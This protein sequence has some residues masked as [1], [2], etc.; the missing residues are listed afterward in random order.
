MI[1]R[2][3]VTDSSDWDSPLPEQYRSELES[4]KTKLQCLED[5]NIRRTYMKHDASLSKAVRREIHIFSDAF[6]KAIAAVAYL[7]AVSPDGEIHVG[8][9]LGKANVGP[10]H[11]N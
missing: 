3:V 5:V 9:I 10:K 2:K 8:I 7:K 4:W 11:E 1:L 6:E